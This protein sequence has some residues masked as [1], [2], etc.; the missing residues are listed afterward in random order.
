MTNNLRQ[1]C[2]K[3]IQYNEKYFE[4]MEYE[5]PN[6]LSDKR[7]Q[8]KKDWTKEEIN[9][10]VV[11]RAQNKI[12][13]KILCNPSLN[14]FVTL[15]FKD[16]YDYESQLYF[17]RLFIR[18]LKTHM[19]QSSF[20]YPL[21][22][23]CVPEYGTKHG[24]FHFHYIAN[25][26]YIPKHKLEELWGLGYAHVQFV[27]DSLQAAAYLSKYLGKSLGQSRHR[28][29]YL[30]SRNLDKP[31]IYLDDDALFYILNHPLH[32]SKKE[33]Y[34]HPFLGNIHKLTYVL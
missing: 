19:V 18:R 8:V 1:Y 32:L 30:S 31:K 9:Q 6:L 16:I 25:Q 27:D 17:F 20:R 24:R 28:K 23:V 13:E 3:L 21:R 5:I 22:Y 29:M 10:K 33:K 26:P 4:W 2:V 7:K 12:R 11:S 14:K 34:A 15:T